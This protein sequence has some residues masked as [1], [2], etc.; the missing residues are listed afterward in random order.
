[1]P[2]SGLLKKAY[3]T[4]ALAAARRASSLR[5]TAGCFPEPPGVSSPGLIYM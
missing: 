2:R 3:G 5:G 4:T 1:M